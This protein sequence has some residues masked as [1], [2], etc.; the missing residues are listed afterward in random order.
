M[1]RNILKSKAFLIAMIGRSQFVIFS[2]I[3]MIFYQGGNL[4]YP[5]EESYNF[6]LNYF[7]D[8]GRT[9]SISGEP[10]LV[11]CL[12]FSISFFFYEVAMLPYF[13]FFHEFFHEEKKRNKL[14]IIG[15]FLGF[16]GIS[17]SIMVA[18][19]PTDVV[20]KLHL[21]FA[22]LPY[23]F[24]IPVIALF[25]LLI[26]KNEKFPNKYAVVYL[27]YLIIVLVY[28]LIVKYSGSFAASVIAQ[29]FNIYAG[30]AC[31][32]IQA[33]GAY[34]LHGNPISTRTAMKKK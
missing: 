33:Y 1:N 7:S 29:K 21:I 32:T 26:I 23:Y 3:G 24:T 19:T 12:I 30:C 4:M 16:I 9:I 14:A 25:I 22:F 34:K 28:L 8:L 20:P 18:F 31:F 5:D 13:V 10:N 11:S 17:T 15:S 2:A 27:I 6:F